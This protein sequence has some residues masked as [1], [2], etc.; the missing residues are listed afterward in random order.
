MKCLAEVTAESDTPYW[1]RR[2]AFL[3]VV[4]HAD[5]ECRDS[6]VIQPR[7]LSTWF[8]GSNGGKSYFILPAFYLERGR[9]FFIN[10]RHRTALLLQHLQL[11]P[12][13]LT[14]TDAESTQY[15]EWMIEGRIQSGDLLELPD[16]SIVDAIY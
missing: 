6:L 8:S 1:V 15:L 2:D 12:M 14:K 7:Y 11:V 9:A 13:S 5:F 4:D 10:G 3:S 16:L